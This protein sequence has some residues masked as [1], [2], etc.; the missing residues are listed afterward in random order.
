MS[1]SSIEGMVG[2]FKAE[3]IQIAGGVPFKL[4]E[5][6]Y[7]DTTQVTFRLGLFGLDKLMNVERTVGDF[8]AALLSIKRAAQAASL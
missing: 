6:S 1:Y 2:K 8:E 7:V 3:G 4:N 5:E